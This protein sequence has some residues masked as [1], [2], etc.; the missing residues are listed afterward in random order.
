[1]SEVPPVQPQQQPPFASQ[2]MP[3]QPEKR[4]NSTLIWII[5]GIV[6][7]CGVF[8]IGIFAAILFPVFS[9]ARYAAQKTSCLSNQKQLATSFIMYAT[10]SDEQLPPKNKPWMDLV[11]PYTESESVF[12]CPSL[13]KDNHSAYGYAANK[14]VLGESFESFI[15]PMNGAL[16][17][18]SVL[19]PRN[20]D[21]G[22]ESLPRPGRHNNAN[23]FA[24]LDGHASSVKDGMPLP[25][26]VPPMDRLSPDNEKTAGQDQVNLDNLDKPLIEK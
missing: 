8:G 15:E 6:A 7:F 26:E 23:N 17:F 19:T 12:H 18:D 11:Q 4:S 3:P 1:M 21:S 22:F 24:F 5:V 25:A 20:A 16:L 14:Y 9:Q 13:S 10:D 2:P